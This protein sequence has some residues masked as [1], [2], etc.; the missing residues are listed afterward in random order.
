MKCIYSF[1]ERPFCWGIYNKNKRGQ[2]CKCYIR[3][4]S[5]VTI[6]LKKLRKGNKDANK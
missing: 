1:T 6:I 2:F 5:K 4:F 3:E